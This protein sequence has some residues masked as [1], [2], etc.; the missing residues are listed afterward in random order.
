MAERQSQAAAATGLVLVTRPLPAAAETARRLAKLGYRVLV[1]PVLAIVPADGL[2]SGDDADAILLTSANAVPALGRLARRDR[3]VFA[4]G[5][6]TAAAAR[7]AGWTRVR[8]GPGD[9][10]RLA[11]LV[12]AELPAGS[13]LLHVAGQDRKAEPGSTLTGRGYTVT[14]WTAYR[15]G[16]VPGLDDAARAALA[17][18]SVSAALHYSRRSAETLVRLA[19]E[20][21]A[22]LRGI[23]HVCLSA[24]V[25]AGLGGGLSARNVAVAERPDEES[26]LTALGAGHGRAGLIDA[27]TRSVEPLS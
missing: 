11:A 10:G 24:D 18:G 21:G 8:S 7:E 5:D 4:V 20:A 19:A 23:R 15:A 9:A 2:P 3:P 17:S 22:D 6:R 13:R 1:A 14:V 12:S 26:L 16:P 27:G 25:A